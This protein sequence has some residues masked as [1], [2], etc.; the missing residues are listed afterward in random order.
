MAKHKTHTDKHEM[1]G[2]ETV[3]VFKDLDRG[4]LDTERFLEKNL[5]SGDKGLMLSFGPGFSAQSILL[6]W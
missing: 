1:E 6:Q 3:E 4:A 5:P 2:K